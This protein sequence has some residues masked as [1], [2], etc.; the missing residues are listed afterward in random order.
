[1]IIS[2][3]LNSILSKSAPAN[4]QLQPALGCTAQLSLGSLPL[5]SAVLSQLPADSC[6][7]S[8]VLSLRGAEAEPPGP[9]E[10]PSG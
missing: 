2:F 9:G 8:P 7:G 5:A 3:E 1:M 6:Q 4:A 10:S